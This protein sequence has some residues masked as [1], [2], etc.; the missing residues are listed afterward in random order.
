MGI[1]DVIFERTGFHSQVERALDLV[2]E[3][4]FRLLTSVCCLPELTEPKPE[5]VH[6]MIETLLPK[7]GYDPAK[8][9]GRLLEL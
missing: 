3:V 2:G 4:F 9:R 8:G 7:A 1:A 6:I 5:A